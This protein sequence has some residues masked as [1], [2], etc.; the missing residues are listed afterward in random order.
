MRMLFLG[1][2]L[3]AATLAPPALAE[4]LTGCRSLATDAERLACYDSL[5]PSAVDPRALVVRLLGDPKAIGKDYDVLG[6]A[7][8]VFHLLP[9]RWLVTRAS[10]S[11]S[12]LEDGEKLRKFC[13]KSGVDI[14]YSTRDPFTLNVT[15]DDPKK[16]TL[17]LR[18]LMIS[19]R[20]RLAEATDMAGTLE[21]LGLDPKKQGLRAA[22]S[23][24]TRAV[25]QATYLPLT[26]DV[27]LLIDA[28]SGEMGTMLRCPAQ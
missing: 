13:E 1:A 10:D 18:D 12:V 16:G 22:Q 11:L 3:F 23:V 9:G 7:G 15:R 5:D 19:T 20:W 8:E 17:H 24:L 4:S 25:T 21:W 26:A 14:A 2:V 27:L 6:N 28:D